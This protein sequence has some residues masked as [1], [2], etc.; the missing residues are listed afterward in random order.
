[1]SAIRASITIDLPDGVD[2]NQY[3]TTIQ[4]QLSRLTGLP[5][6]INVREVD[7]PISMSPIAHLSK[8]GQNKE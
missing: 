4:N 5:C 7:D 2:Y 1:M 3:V 8:T 6:K